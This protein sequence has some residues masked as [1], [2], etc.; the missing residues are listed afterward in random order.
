MIDIFLLWLLIYVYFSIKGSKCDEISINIKRSQN[1]S[2]LFFS[3]NYICF[4]L[5]LTVVHCYTTRNSKINLIWW[6]SFNISEKLKMSS[7]HPCIS[8]RM[9]MFIIFSLDYFLLFLVFL[10]LITRNIFI[11][12]GLL[13]SKPSILSLSSF[14]VFLSC[15]P[16][17]SPLYSLIIYLVHVL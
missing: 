9:S 17:E 2:S 15:E 16:E 8:Y 14:S 11:K 6:D 13:T 3:Y 12:Y 5:S 7:M 4:F 10:V 1:K